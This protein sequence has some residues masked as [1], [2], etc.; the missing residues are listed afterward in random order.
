MRECGCK[1]VPT[2]AQLRKKQTVIAHQVDISSKHH[3][4]ALGNH[5][6]M[7]HPAK[8]FA[9][10]W[11]NPLIRPH[12]QLYPEVSG[13]IK[14]SWQAA[15]WVTEVSL[16]E[17]CPM[18]ADWKYQPHRHYYIKE[19]AQLI[20]NT[21]VVPLRWITVNGEEH[22]DALP[23]YYIEDVYEFHIQTV[24]LVQHIPTSLLHRNFLDLQK[25]SP[26]FTM[27]HPLR[28][29]ANGRP[30]FR[31]RIMPWSDD[32]SGN[33][34]KQY[35]AHTNIYAVS[36]NLPHKK[37]SQEF[38]VR[39]CSTSGNASSSEQFAALAKDFATDVW[40]EAYDCELEMDILFQIIPHLLPADNPQQAETSSHVGG[41][42]NLPCRQD[43]IGGTKNQKETDAGYKAFFS[44][45]T[46]RTVTFTIQT[47]RQQ[48]WLA[49]LGDHDALALSY[50]QTGVKDK[51]SQFWISQLCAQAA[52]KQKTLFFDP[53]LRDPRLVDKRIK[54]IEWKSVKL[55][56]KQAIQRELWAWLITQPPENFEKLD[57]SD[58]SRKDL[59]PGVHYNAL[60]AIP[61]L[62]PH[63]DTP[64][65]ILH[66]FQLGADK[67]IWHDTNKGWDKSKD[68][69][70]GIRL[71]ASSVDGLSIPPI[72]ARYMM[73]YKNSL[74]GKHFKTLQQVGIFHLQGLASESLFSIWRATGDLG[75]HLWVTEIRSL[76]LYLHD[77]K[78]L[79]DN[80]LDSWAV[81][82]P[83]RILVKMKLHVL[84]HLPDD[85]RRFGLVILYS[86]EIFECWNAIFRMCSV[87]SNHLSP[88]HDIAITLSEMEVFKH[89]V[90]GGWWRAENG[91]MIQAGVKVRQFLVQSPELQRR[92]GWV[93]QNQKY[94][95]RPIPRNRQPRLRD[96]ILWEQIYTLYNIPEPHPP[97][98]S[99][100]WDLCK[101]IIA[102]SKDICLEGSWVF[103]KSKDVCDTLSGRILKLLVRSGS[104]P[105]TSLA[106]CIINCFNILE[107]RDRRL[108]MPV[109]QAPE[110]ARVLPIP[111]KDV[112]FVFNAQHDC[113]TGGCQITSAS[114]FERQERIETGIPKK[115]IQH[116]DCQQYIVN[117]HALHNS[118]LLRD[119]LPRYL[120]EPIPLVKDRQ[121]KHQELA[122]QLRI[123]GPAKRAE[124]QE[125]S[126]Q[127][128][129][130]N[131]GLKMAQGGLQL[132]TV[133]EANEE[134]EVDEDTVMDDV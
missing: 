3:I 103:F 37:L 101:S 11:S 61:G 90:S 4:S 83:N 35:N 99:N 15:K 118:N 21:F 63:H 1:D 31:M 52:E 26:S 9:L 48:L 113:V 69:L 58:P 72:R 89:L 129:K 75:A 76:E 46:P 16:D 24:E 66:S 19:I 121:Q 59:R 131:K 128:R 85:V 81:Y 74:I 108:G 60:L 125:K 32:V 34:S 107:T 126:K 112:L 102:Q 120:T 123:S 2:F 134:E 132:P 95:L 53:T 43:L 122:A 22:M 119:T 114:S 23:A 109:L 30:I 91:E 54:G 45:G 86:T 42:G 51:L 27:P 100:M 98:E 41:Q 14:E 82:D 80:L 17:L 20:N 55:S 78:I 29:K 88:S 106:I 12:M 92:L 71:Q 36:L 67:Y 70:F 13:P 117:M 18:W 84:T 56:I 57:L 130:R 93:S 28:A 77:L 96:S 44:P 64:V 87:L 104:D 133:L 127:T 38:F 49:C 8:L 25:T 10:D 124:I 5:F 68:E 50:A 94:V 105:K 111:A 47:I 115:I 65:E 97:S 116:S 79:V 39:F 7:N 62:D 33:V 40:H 6:Y 110:H 73:Q